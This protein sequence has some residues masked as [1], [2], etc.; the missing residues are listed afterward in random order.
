MTRGARAVFDD[1][2]H[3]FGPAFQRHVRGGRRVGC[4]LAFIV[5]LLRVGRLAARTGLQLPFLAQ[6]EG[7][8]AVLRPLHNRA[9]VRQLLAGLEPLDQARKRLAAII[10]TVGRILVLVG[11]LEGD[12]FAVF[13]GDALLWSVR[14]EIHQAE[15]VDGQHR[16][17]A[18]PRLDGERVVRDEDL[19]VSE[20]H[21][22]LV[23][24]DVQR[25]LLH[26][27]DGRGHQHVCRRRRRLP[28]LVQWVFLGNLDAERVVV[29][30][31]EGERQGVLERVLGVLQLCKQLFFGF[32]HAQAAL[33]NRIAGA[34][35]PVLQE[36]VPLTKSRLVARL[37]LL[38]VDRRGGRE[39]EQ[40]E[41]RGSEH[42]PPR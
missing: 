40:E 10:R 26:R 16:L 13:V 23:V 6:L 38:P 33:H 19:R 36:A 22:R 27:L 1:L 8:V 34:Q 24:L 31:R 37:E 14:L 41:R 5:A 17:A 35:R 29:E 3:L 2:A 25:H 18:H 20:A 28:A 32:D 7:K 15:V 9:A 4:E 42:Q 12:G 11:P 21:D 30:Q 39:G